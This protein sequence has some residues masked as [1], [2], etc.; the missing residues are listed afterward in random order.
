GEATIENIFI[1][2]IMYFTYS[3]LWLFVAIK[4]MIEYLKD[5]IFKR[6]V[7]WYKTERF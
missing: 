2:A 1:V 6:E 4:G 7:K 3:Q 5:I